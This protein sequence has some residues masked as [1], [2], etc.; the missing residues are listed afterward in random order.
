[1]EVMKIM[2]W[3]TFSESL[4]MNLSNDLIDLKESL[5]VFYDKIMDSIG[6]K[7][8]DIFEE[9]KLSR[10]FD[11]DLK[12]IE[13]SSSFLNSLLSLGLRMSSINNTDDYETWIDRPCRFLLI[14]KMESN[15]IEEPEYLLIQTW[16]DSLD[17]WSDT[18]MYKL[19]KINDFYDKLTSKKIIVKDGG[20]DRIYQST[21]SN[22]WVLQN[23][24]KETDKWKK[25]FRLDDFQKII[26]NVEIEIL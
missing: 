26:S 4:K 12:N 8:L 2:N 22:E 16:L 15:D 25:Y 1:M 6:A 18:K 20:V 10:D 19:D 9:L 17:K 14:Y 5:T 21:N 7:E 13:K 11:V 3:I 23:I 24:D